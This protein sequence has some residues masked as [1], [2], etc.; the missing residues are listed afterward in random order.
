MTEKDFEPNFNVMTLNPHTLPS[1]I[2]RSTNSGNTRS[3]ARDIP[4]HRSDCNPKGEASKPDHE[5]RVSGDRC[6]T[7]FTLQP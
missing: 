3:Q 6:M 7:A 5:T 1:E 2:R 4:E